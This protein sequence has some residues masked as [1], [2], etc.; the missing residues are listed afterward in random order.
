MLVR[1]NIDVAD[2]QKMFRP[3]LKFCE[4]PR[5][6][7]RTRVLW[8]KINKNCSNCSK[9]AITRHDCVHSEMVWGSNP[10]TRQVFP[11]LLSY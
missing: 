11:E 3:R 2:F 7:G 9:W 8:E 6:P 4:A 5:L 1:K 10:S